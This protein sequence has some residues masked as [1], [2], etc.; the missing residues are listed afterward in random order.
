[1]TR[2]FILPSRAIFLLSAAIHAGFAMFGGVAPMR[3]AVFTPSAMIN[4]CA[5]PSRTAA[6]SAQRVNGAL[7]ASRLV[8]VPSSASKRH[9]PSDIPSA[10]APPIARFASASDPHD[11]LLSIAIALDE[12]LSSARPTFAPTVRIRSVENPSTGPRPTSMCVVPTVQVAPASAINVPAL[13][14]F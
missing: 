14:A 13:T 8:A 1:M 12:I 7:R 9:V 5:K 11:A 3:R 6:S 4:P 10:N 2:T